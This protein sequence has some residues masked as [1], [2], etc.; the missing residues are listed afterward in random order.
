MLT[1]DVL[2]LIALELDS[3]TLLNFQGAAKSLSHVCDSYFW[4]NKINKDFGLSYTEYVQENFERFVTYK[5]ILKNFTKMSPQEHYQDIDNHLSHETIFDFIKLDRL[6]LVK[7]Y[8]YTGKEINCLPEGS[9][10]VNG[11]N[12]VPIFQAILEKKE[13][14]F[15]FLSQQIISEEDFRF[16]MI[17][18]FEQGPVIDKTV[19]NILFVKFYDIILP[20]AIT[21]EVFK[22]HKGFWKT[23]YQKLEEFNNVHPHI[24]GDI[25]QRRIEFYRQLSLNV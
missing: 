16:I 22:N 11:R 20:Q 3:E 17:N 1:K 9:T 24:F 2:S 19:R 6:D 10:V 14:I 8:V 4:I 12:L 18:L 5:V 13:T 7:A 23:A 21:V 25:Y 15:E